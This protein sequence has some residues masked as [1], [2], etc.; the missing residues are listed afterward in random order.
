MLAQGVS[1]LP[2]QTMRPGIIFFCSLWRVENTCSEHFPS[3]FNSVSLC[4]ERLADKRL[5]RGHKECFQMIN[6]KTFFRVFAREKW[7]LSLVRRCSTFTLPSVFKSFVQLHTTR[8]FSRFPYLESL[9]YHNQPQ[10]VNKNPSILTRV[11]STATRVKWEAHKSSARHT[12]F[13]PHSFP[14][15]EHFFFQIWQWGRGSPC[16]LSDRRIQTRGCPSH[17][18]KEPQLYMSEKKLGA[19]PKWW[20]LCQNFVRKKVVWITTLV[21]NSLP[22]GHSI[23]SRALCYNDGSFRHFF[24]N[25]KNCWSHD[26]IWSASQ[27]HT[28]KSGCNN[29]LA[30]AFLTS[31]SKHCIGPQVNFLT[32][33]SKIWLC[34]TNVKTLW[35]CMLHP[36]LNLPDNTDW[37]CG[38]ASPVSVPWG[39]HQVPATNG[40]VCGY[41][42][43]NH[44]TILLCTELGSNCC[45]SSQVK[46]QWTNIIV[47][48][49][50]C[51]WGLGCFLSYLHHI[52]A[53]VC[54]FGRVKAAISFC[55]APK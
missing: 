46:V 1:H 27:T 23:L 18:H 39:S 3:A 16:V 55:I 37:S 6:I 38:A 7:I 17:R 31:A 30:V 50:V 45:G 11:S 26:L 40:Y 43:N 2:K 52:S 53:M 22:S 44:T 54:P 47:M 9:I 41:T 51:G 33:T 25:N 15:M 8:P 19:S 5:R 12:A 4:H 10:F 29:W 21:F 36:Q 28:P 49:L 42:A 35:I 13:T 32:L 20:M 48:N 34:I 14:Y 24:L